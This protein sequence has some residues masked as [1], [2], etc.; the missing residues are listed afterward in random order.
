[1]A[2]VVLAYVAHLV[3]PCLVV[4]IECGS[5]VHILAADRSVGVLYGRAG[6]RS[7]RLGESS[8]T[9]SCHNYTGP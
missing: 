5:H 7:D 1:M 2:Y 3:L 6:T 9:R 4:D 8:P